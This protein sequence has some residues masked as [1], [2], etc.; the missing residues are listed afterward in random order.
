MNVYDR[1]K[2]RFENGEFVDGNYCKLAIPYDSR[3]KLRYVP[4]AL[5]TP[6]YCVNALSYGNGTIDD[7]PEESR[8]RE[9]FLHLLINIQLCLV[10]IIVLKLCH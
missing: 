9:F 10:I 1:I 3:T 4:I 2:K 8:T 5:R 7:V 6:G